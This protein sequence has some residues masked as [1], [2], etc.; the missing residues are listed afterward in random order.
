MKIV[1]EAFVSIFFITALVFIAA[2]VLGVQM[3]VNDAEEFQN[4]MVKKIE[5]SNFNSMVIDECVEQANVKGY[6]LSVNVKKEDVFTCNECNYQ[7]PVDEEVVCP[8]CGDDSIRVK[9]LYHEGCIALS[10]KV[11][12]MLMGIEESGTI[13][14]YA[15]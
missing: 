9:H 15:R 7:W 11:K 10:Y 14:S 5:N 1:I 2:Q 12:S 4:N 13:V 3:Q 6:I 8:T